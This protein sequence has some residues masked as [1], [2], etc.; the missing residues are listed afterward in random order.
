MILYVGRIAAGKGIEHLIAATRAIPDAHLALLGPDDRH[1]AS[2]QVAA[3]MT[4][5]A[6][7]G[8]IH[9][10]P[11]TEGPPL[12][13]YREASVFVLASAGDSFGL[14]AAEAAAAG[15]PVIVTDRCGIAS[16]FEPGEAVVVYDD[17]AEVVAAITR[18][19]GDA[20]LRATLSAGALAAARRNTWERAV[21]IQEAAYRAAASRTRSTNA[22]TLGLV[23][24]VGHDEA[25]RLAGMCPPCGIS[26]EPSQ[27][28]LTLP[29][30]RRRQRGLRSR[31]PA[32]RSGA[33]PTRSESTSGSPLAA[34]SF[35][36]TPQGSRDETNAKTSAADVELGKPIGTDVARR[37]EAGRRARAQGCSSAAPSGPLPATTSTRLGPRSCDGPHEVVQLL[38]GRE[39]GDREHDHVVRCNVELGPEVRPPRGEALLPRRPGSDIDRV[40]E[41]PDRRRIQPADL[42][43]PTRER[44][45]NE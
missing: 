31:R 13:A 8:R 7:S 22:S 17:R 1:G 12:A 33:A 5:P 21:E 44:A 27:A 28:Q 35:T 14:A 25:R 45:E 4:E 41:D 30:R 29:R 38:L 16:F 34:A 32:D 10:L 11:P 3:A 36:T 39:A 37:G 43:P 6:L 40:R 18:V 24:P 15:A 20:G 19:L 26:R 9:R 23:A 42:E 2:E